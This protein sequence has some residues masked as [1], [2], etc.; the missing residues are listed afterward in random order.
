MDTLIDMH[1]QA[2]LAHPS[3]QPFWEAARQGRLMLPRCLACGRCHWYP[4][5]FCPLCQHG[6]VRWEDASGR[7]RL[8][9]CTGL[10]RDPSRTVMAFVELEEGPLML[11]HLVGRELADWRIGDALQVAFRALETGLHLPVFQA[12]AAVLPAA[13]PAQGASGSSS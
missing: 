2:V 11:T 1:R 12:P 6:P 8:H 4:R 5:A 10:L 9:A 3:S 13:Q 7:A